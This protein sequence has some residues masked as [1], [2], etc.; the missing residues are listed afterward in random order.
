MQIISV[1]VGL[2]REVNWQGKTVS[3]G[4]FKSSV[5]GT[6]AVRFLNLDGDKQADLTVHGGRDKAVYVYPSEHY[7]YWQKELAEL[8][9]WPW[10]IFGENLTIKGLLETDICI[11]DRL[12]IGSVELEVSQP[13]SPCY[14]LGIRFDRS[15]MVKRFLDS[16]LSGFYCRV[17]Q[18]GELATGDAL[19]LTHRDKYQV[20]IAE[21]AL[22]SANKR[23]DPELLERAL[24]VET[25]AKSW[26]KD[27]QIKLNKITHRKE[28]L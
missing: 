11:G 27:L 2:P 28:S 23:T 9:E 7:A 14:K 20:S 6:V 15:D 4:I 3:T 1:N 17:L 22:I 13:R 24:E 21:L 16:G 5:N 10:G 18:E 19:K 12:Q 25:L 26:R 8:K